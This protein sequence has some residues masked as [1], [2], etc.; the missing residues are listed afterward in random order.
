MR[1]A[2]NSGL[3]VK[4]RAL[5]E[6]LKSTR[7]AAKVLTLYSFSLADIVEDYGNGDLVIL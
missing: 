3:K 4:F 1:M 7:Y 5:L 2:Q 6:A